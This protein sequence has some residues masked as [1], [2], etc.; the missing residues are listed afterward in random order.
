M[1][2][3]R[4]CGELAA[5]TFE[6]CWKCGTDREG[7]PDPNFTPENDNPTIMIKD[8]NRKAA[9]NGLFPCEM[10]SGAF[11]R[12][13]L[14]IAMLLQAAYWS[15]QALTLGDPWDCSATVLS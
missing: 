4:H 10:L 7:T 13:C 11:S 3:C 1:W 5:H 12:S 14:V 15:I 6:V 9:T 8:A 2:Q